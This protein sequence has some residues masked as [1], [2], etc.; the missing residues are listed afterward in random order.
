VKVLDLFCGCGGF[1]LGFES[2]GFKIVM[3][4]D[5]WRLRRGDYRKYAGSDGGGVT[6]G[7]IRV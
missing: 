5:N 2:A 6:C 7:W 3:E 4:L 1:S